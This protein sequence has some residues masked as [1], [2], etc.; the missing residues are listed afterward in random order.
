MR[1]SVRNGGV[2]A[3]STAAPSSD[4][5]HV[6]LV[7]QQG[8]VVGAHQGVDELGERLAAQD[9]VAALD[10]VHG[11]RHG[12][13]TSAAAAS[14][15]SC[16]ARTRA[17]RCG[18]TPRNVR[19]PATSRRVRVPISQPTASSVTAGRGGNEHAGQQAELAELGDVAGVQ[20]RGV[21]RHRHLHHHPAGGPA[22]RAAP[23]RR[24]PPVSAEPLTTTTTPVVLAAT[25]AG[26]VRPGSE[27]TTTRPAPA[28]TTSSTAAGAGHAGAHGLPVGVR[29]VSWPS[30]ARARRR[31]R[32]R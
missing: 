6:E 29:G 8:A 10:Q 19:T 18:S 13:L 28:A 7:D 26:A 15:A 30:A 14:V 9:V 31:H 12:R 3:A 32:A 11:D 22:G 17:K 16:T 2:W 5:V 20:R 25:T 27:G 4:L 21:G 24:P 23:A 1:R